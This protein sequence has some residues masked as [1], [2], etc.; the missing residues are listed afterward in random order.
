MALRRECALVAEHLGLGATAIG[1]AGYERAASYAQAFFALSVGF[2]RGAKLALTLDSVLSS[3]EFLDAEALKRYGHRLDRL[4]QAVERL[5]ASHGITDAALPDTPIHRAIVATLTDFAANVSRYYNLEILTPGSTA[6]D[7][8]IA[9]WYREVTQPVLVAHYSEARRRLDE[10]KADAFAVPA[11]TYVFVDVTLETGE[12]IQN[13]RDLL[14]RAAEVRVSRPWERMYVLQLARFVTRV[15]GNLG[16]LAQQSGLP[17]PY[18]EEFFYMF[19]RDDRDFR[20]RKIWS[21]QSSG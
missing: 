14:L 18:L 3:R 5:A 2:E 9:A 12:A 10:E 21:I 6:A 7:D 15:I 19:Q 1:D 17:V 13:P 11:S 20:T 4:L 16:G 8:P